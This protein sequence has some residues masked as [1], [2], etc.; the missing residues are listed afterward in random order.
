LSPCCAAVFLRRLTRDP[1][2]DLVVGVYLRALGESLD[3]E[4][5]DEWDGA[6][7]DAARGWGL[8]IAADGAAL[9]LVRQVSD[10][11]EAADW[12]AKLERWLAEVRARAPSGLSVEAKLAVTT[13]TEVFHPERWR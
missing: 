8:V 3:P 12:R 6:V 5:F 10:A 7:R 13:T 1:A 2:N 4:A 11:A 9:L